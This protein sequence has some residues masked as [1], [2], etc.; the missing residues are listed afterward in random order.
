M[1]SLLVR[2]CPFKGLIHLF[3]NSRDERDG[4]SHSFRPTHAANPV[5]LVYNIRDVTIKTMNK[6]KTEQITVYPAQLD[7]WEGN[8]YYSKTN[9][10]IYNAF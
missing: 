1:F 2:K 3:G 8:H 4:Q 7:K 10:F 9:P 5:H 6:K